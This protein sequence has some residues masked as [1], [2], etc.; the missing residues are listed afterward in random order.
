MMCVPVFSSPYGPRA[1]HRAAAAAGG[2]DQ[3]APRDQTGPAADV[4]A[5]I[6]AVNRWTSWD[7]S[8]EE[9][10][11]HI[12]PFSAADEESLRDAAA[13]VGLLLMRRRGEMLLAAAAA[14][15]GGAG[16]LLA[17]GSLSF[18][19]S[20]PASVAR[21]RL[22]GVARR[23]SGALMDLRVNPWALKQEELMG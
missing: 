6:V 8:A 7:E 4:V 3:F 15:A 17:G 2:G 13:S 20:L 14:G 22:R 11:R 21:Q 1:A 5:V 23:G 9:G 10:E 16:G 12:V 19:A 18:V